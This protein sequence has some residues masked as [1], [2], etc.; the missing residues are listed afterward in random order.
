M[1]IFLFLCSGNYY[2]SRFAE[3]FFN[4]HAAHLG[5]TWRA[6][7]RGL[8]RDLNTLNNPG[9][10]SA[11]AVAELR[12]HGIEPRDASRYPLSVQEADLAGATRIVALFESEHR[13]MVQ[14]DHPHWLSRIEFWQI[15]DLADAEPMAAMA[16]LARNVQQLLRHLAANGRATSPGHMA[17]P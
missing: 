5:L 10:M 6:E 13:P 1:R 3:E 17:A 9:P 4:H 11:F 16:A 14:R 8:M 12:R 15:G 7:S 2:R